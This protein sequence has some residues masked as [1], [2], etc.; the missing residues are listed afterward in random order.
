MLKT[1]RLFA[2]SVCFVMIASQ[3]GVLAQSGA[4]SDPAGNTSVVTDPDPVDPLRTTKHG[5]TG[6]TQQTQTNTA[7]R[8][9]IG[10]TL[11][12]RMYLNQQTQ[13]QGDDNTIRVTYRREEIKNSVEQYRIEA[14]NRREAK[15]LQ[16]RQQLGE[17]SDERK[18][19]LVER[20]DSMLAT[21]NENRIQ[22]YSNILQN[23]VA[24]L[25]RIIQRTQAAS[26]NGVDISVVNERITAA[27][28]AIDSAEEKLLE[29]AG[30]E[31][32]VVLSDDET[33][34]TSVRTAKDEL[35]TDLQIVFQAVRDA[36]QAVRDAAIALNTAVSE[37]ESGQETI[38]Q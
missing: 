22:A 5:L 24:I 10:S 30:N 17:L 36:H 4:Y 31:Y 14:R 16:L 19:N 8:E 33:P 37:F 26:D 9:Q 35:K 7:A 25:N 28:E 6:T 1:L 27:Q 32:T 38:T 15:L 13:N 18:A 20:L 29:Q 3:S 12:E 23:V 21:V 11:Q 34:G 2:I